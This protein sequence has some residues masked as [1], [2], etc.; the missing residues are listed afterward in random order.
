[1]YENK[2]SGK[3][4]IIKC[5]H[6]INDNDSSLSLSLCSFPVSI[7]KFFQSLATNVQK[8]STFLKIQKIL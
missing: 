2:S 1:M 4:F 6:Y 5:F 8:T 7:F 3:F